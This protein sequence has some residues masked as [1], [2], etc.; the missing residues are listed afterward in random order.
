MLLA[1]ETTLATEDLPIGPLRE[2][3]RLATGFG[4]ENLQ[5]GL[6]ESQLRA[7]I[8]LIE[9]RTGKILLARRFRLEL[10]RWRD[11]RAQALPVAPVSTIHSLVLRDSDGEETTVTP[12][13]Y[14]L[15]PDG[16][17]PRLLPRGNALPSIPRSGQVLIRFDAGFGS[18]WQAIPA[19]LAQAVLLLAAELYE[20][21]HEGAGAEAGLPY[22]VQIL[23]ERWRT[24]RVLGGG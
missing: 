15:M 23:I 10:A 22:G 3:L 8:V 7:A 11:R 14:L 17:R 9:A 2:H 21:R 4:E 6:L 12:G 19:D 20:R 5:D 1:E 13:D 16:Q 18:S 24:V